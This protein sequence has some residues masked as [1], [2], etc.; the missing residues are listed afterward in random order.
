MNHSKLISLVVFLAF[1]VSLY[2]QNNNSRLE[3]ANKLLKEKKY[4]EAVTAYNDILKTDEDNTM[5]WYN[6]ASAEYNL[7]YYDNAITAY[8]NAM[9]NL[10]GPI[11]RY[12]I[13]CAYALNG[14][15]EMALK[16]LQEAADKGFAQYQLMASDNDLAGIKNAKKFSEIMEQVKKNG[17]PCLARDEY[18]QFNFWVGKW[19]VINPAGQHAGD[20]EID[21]MN[22]GCTVVENWYGSGNFQGKSF[23]YF[24]TTDN[25]W[26]QFWINQN[27]QKTTYEGKLENGNMVFY[28][29]DH[30]KDNNNPFLRRLTFFNLGPNKVRQYSERSTD[31]GKT[32]S[33]EYDFTYVRK[34][35]SN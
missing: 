4:E 31:D 7:K 34:T 16:Y 3:E 23:N 19:D 8:Q 15:K 28:S 26:H 12:N 9:K 5:A 11:V 25:Y 18:N 29:Y 13:A 30:V 22:N 17:N 35:N 14:N 10:A 21:I 32:W 20:S 33:V 6:L 1:S 27:A 24:D 2:S